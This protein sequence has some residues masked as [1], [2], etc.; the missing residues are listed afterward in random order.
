MCAEEMPPCT[1]LT[2]KREKK[3]GDSWQ[4]V[5]YKSFGLYGDWV[6]STQTNTEKWAQKK[7]ELAEKQGDAE[8]SDVTAPR[9]L[10]SPPALVE[11]RAQFPLVKQEKQQYKK[12]GTN[13]TRSGRGNA[14]F[15]KRGKKILTMNNSFLNMA[16]IGDF[17]PLNTSVPATKVEITVSCRWAQ[18]ST[19]PDF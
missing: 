8:E 14:L 18:C 9:P 15:K 7:P 1:E 6:H 3:A 5:V 4:E 10:P 16:S 13:E 12:G 19:W 17:D 11:A 2:Q